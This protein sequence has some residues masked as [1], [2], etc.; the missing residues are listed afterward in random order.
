MGLKLKD[1]SI[2]FFADVN[3][4][5]VEPVIY[6]G[7]HEGHGIY[8]FIKRNSK[9]LSSKFGSTNLFGTSMLSLMKVYIG[10]DEPEHFLNLHNIFFTV[11]EA[12]SFIKVNIA[13]KI[14][15][16][17][18]KIQVLEEKLKSISSGQVEE[19]EKTTNTFSYAMN[20]IVKHFNE[21]IN[22]PNKTSI[23]GNQGKTSNGRL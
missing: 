16:M 23:H 14:I 10:N 11:E 2:L 4:Q 21:Y 20:D 18:S 3:K 6:T 8:L 5:E 17:N 19:A 7:H 12:T 15:E 9:L 13:S 22:G 1:F